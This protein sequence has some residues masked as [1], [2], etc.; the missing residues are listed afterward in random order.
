MLVEILKE[1]K[2]WIL[3]SVYMFLVGIGIGAAINE[4]IHKWKK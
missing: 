2:T 4:I 1:Q 3:I